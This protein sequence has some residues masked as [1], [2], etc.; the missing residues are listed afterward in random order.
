M[1]K[2]LWR[3]TVCGLEQELEEKA[4]EESLASNKEHYRAAALTL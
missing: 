2:V 1:L 4:L 3:G